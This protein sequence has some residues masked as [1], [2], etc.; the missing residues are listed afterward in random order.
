VGFREV[1]MM[2]RMG[3]GGCRKC[4]TDCGGQWEVVVVIE[5]LLWQMRGHGA[6]R[7]L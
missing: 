1:R 6:N 4:L 3:F 5:R 2:F 7:M